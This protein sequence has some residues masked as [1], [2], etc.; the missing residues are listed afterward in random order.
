[1][2]VRHQAVHPARK[3]LQKQLERLQ[4]LLLRV[5]RTQPRVS[6]APPGGGHAH[7]AQLDV[8]TPRV[9]QDVGVAHQ[10]AAR[11]GGH[12]RCRLQPPH[13]DMQVAQLQIE[14]F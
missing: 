1:M 9:E 14:N 8:P 6:S 12:T 3:F 10:Q 7:L 11:A 5:A 2:C 4:K 13:N